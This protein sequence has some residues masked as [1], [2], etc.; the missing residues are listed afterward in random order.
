MISAGG[1]EGRNGVGRELGGE[2][3]LEAP[4]WGPGPLRSGEAVPA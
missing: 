1:G 2:A 4:L 3:R